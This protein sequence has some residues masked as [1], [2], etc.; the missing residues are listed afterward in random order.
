MNCYKFEKSFKIYGSIDFWKSGTCCPQLSMKEV[1]FDLIKV[2]NKRFIDIHA[3]FLISFLQV[4][5]RDYCQSDRFHIQ[6]LKWVKVKRFGTGRP[7]KSS[8]VSLKKRK[9]RQSLPV[10]SSIMKRLNHFWMWCRQA[11]FSCSPK[12]IP[13]IYFHSNSW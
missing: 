5:T 11:S 8:K 1:C 3:M 12:L 10:L 6:I 13:F 4:D 7:V 2:Q 9:R